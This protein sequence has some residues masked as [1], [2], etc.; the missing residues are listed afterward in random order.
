[1]NQG[2]E[3]GYQETRYAGMRRVMGI[4][5]ALQR[6]EG[7]ELKVGDDLLSHNSSTIGA[8]RFNFS[9][10]NGKRWNPVAIVT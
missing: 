9:V 8:G 4:K 6:T 1:M 7:L 2:R 5:K 10:R 3:M